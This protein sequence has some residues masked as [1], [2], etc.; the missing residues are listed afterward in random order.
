MQQQ[1]TTKGFTIIEVI[2]STG[3]FL[4]ITI[5]AIATLVNSTRH[6]HATNEI[7]QSIDTL[8][9]AMEDIARNLTTGTNF[10]CITGSLNDPADLEA[11][12]PC[13]MG[14]VTSG[15]EGSLALVFETQDGTIGDSSDQNMYC[16]N[17]ST[18][19][20][21][22]TTQADTA[23]PCGTSGPYS[24]ITPDNMV[25]DPTRSGFSVS[26]E[27]V[28][29]TD[30]KVRLINV[31]LVGEITYQNSKIP[32]DVQTTITPRTFY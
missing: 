29:L 21:Y 11:P 28:N 30:D 26:N 12:N 5:I 14:A 17:A 1:T 16:I 22:K 32:F 9:F 31:R 13:P 15:R 6:Y 4:V 25:I 10:H 24:I 27:V 7:R 19:K 3:L 18:K 23:G 8:N 2:I 20:L